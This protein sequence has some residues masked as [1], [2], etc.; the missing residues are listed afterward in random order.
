MRLAR[1]LATVVLVKPSGAR[2]PVGTVEAQPKPVFTEVRESPKPRKQAG[3]CEPNCGCCFSTDIF[4]KAALREPKP[5]VK[6][7]ARCHARD[8]WAQ[9]P[10]QDSVERARSTAFTLGPN[11]E[12]II[13]LDGRL[14]EHRKPKR[15]R[16]LPSAFFVRI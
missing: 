8:G 16:A 2:I 9:F 11:P 6:L 13:T 4:S 3:V 5:R 10:P 14:V 12:W 1:G 7:R 15:V